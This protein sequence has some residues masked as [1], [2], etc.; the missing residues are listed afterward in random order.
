MMQG[1]RMKYVNIFLKQ[2][3]RK[4]GRML[5]DHFEDDTGNYLLGY[6]SKCIIVCKDGSMFQ[7][8]GDWQWWVEY[9]GTKKSYGN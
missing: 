9:L 6:K 2:N 8:L 5:I 3:N 1:K 7:D 4:F